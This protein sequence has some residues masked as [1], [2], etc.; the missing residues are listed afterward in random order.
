M[1]VSFTEWLDGCNFEFASTYNRYGYKV[2][3]GFVVFAGMELLDSEKMEHIKNLSS[4]DIEASEAAKAIFSDPDIFYA[5]DD[6]PSIAM[7]NVIDQLKKEQEECR[8][9]P[10]HRG[11]YE[12]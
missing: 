10:N 1:G 2:G 6:C 5:V 4:G 8:K 7:N 12:Y 11:N 3:H 9:S